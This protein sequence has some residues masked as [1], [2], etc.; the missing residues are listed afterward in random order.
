MV[1]E[2][3]S[4]ERGGGAC[5]SLQFQCTAKQIR[6]VN[7]KLINVPKPKTS[8]TQ[9]KQ[10]KGLQE[11]KPIPLEKAEALKNDSSMA[12][13]ALEGLINWFKK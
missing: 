2:S 5:A 10:K 4:V 6:F 9:P 3:L 11:T 1:L 7:Q 8:R 12:K 13:G